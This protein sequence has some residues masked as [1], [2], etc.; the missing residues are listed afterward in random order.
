MRRTVLPLAS[1]ALALL[2]AGAVHLAAVGEP[3]HAAFPGENGD[4]AFVASNAMGDNGFTLAPTIF[5]RSADGSRYTPLLHSDTVTTPSW[6]PDGEKIVFVHEGL[7]N[8]DELWVMDVDGSHQVKLTDTPGY[9]RHPA[10]FPDGRRIA[11]SSNRKG[12]DPDIY[13]LTLNA[14]RDD[15][16]GTK[17]LT[18]RDSK[19][20]QPAVSPSGKRVAFASDR[21]GGEA[22]IFSMR[23]GRVEGPGGQNRPLRLTENG[24]GSDPDTDP[25]WAP[26]GQKIVFTSQR[27][28]NAEVYVM[29][30]GG[31][32][33]QALT[34]GAS[35]EDFQ[36]A[37]S[38]DGQRI[39]FV[40]LDWEDDSDWFG[41]I[42]TMDTNGSN[43]ADAITGGPFIIYSFFREPTWQPIPGA[44]E[45]AGQ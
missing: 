18:N 11:V 26:D 12:G 3:A 45:G 9:N 30:A 33:E 17:R 29:D 19:D 8:N 34:D 25:D 32:N 42:W 4:I 24:E 35:T 1:A 23:T 2:L 44:T 36:P 10:W 21:S 31:G 15:V 5:L 37:F 16:T 38:P 40:R 7:Y 13:V 39:A 41:S 43:P 22:A 27:T 14:A 28:G 20:F 6:S